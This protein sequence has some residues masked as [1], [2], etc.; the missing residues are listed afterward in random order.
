[1][2]AKEM[3]EGVLAIINGENIESVE[4]SS[5]IVRRQSF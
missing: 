5:K 4:V 3:I 2:L 1:M